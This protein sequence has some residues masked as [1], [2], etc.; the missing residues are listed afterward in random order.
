MKHDLFNTKTRIFLS[1]SLNT[2]LTNKFH[3][4]F[5]LSSLFTTLKLNPSWW[6]SLNVLPLL[7]SYCRRVVVSLWS[8]GPRCLS[9]KNL[10]HYSIRVLIDT[11]KLNNFSQMALISSILYILAVKVKVFTIKIGLIYPK[12]IVKMDIKTIHKLCC[13]NSL[14]YFYFTLPP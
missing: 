6:T 3:Q 10:F 1:L 8:A 11:L 4:L 2:R 13:E 12:Y 5:Y 14:I 7:E 9:Y